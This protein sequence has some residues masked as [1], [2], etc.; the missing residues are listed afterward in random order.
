MLLLDNN[1][2]TAMHS[3]ILIQVGNIFNDIIIANAI[4][5]YY[6]YCIHPSIGKYPWF[7]GT[8]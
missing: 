4:C 1:D 2:M 7:F 6:G 8:L 5:Y 3:Y